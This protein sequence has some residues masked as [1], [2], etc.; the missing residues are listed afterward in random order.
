[1]ALS[2][3]ASGAPANDSQ[4]VE[5]G[6]ITL[7]TQAEASKDHRATKIA[8][9]HDTLLRE[10]FVRERNVA[11]SE[12]FLSEA[13]D[14]TDEASFGE[15]RAEYRQS[16]EQICD[17]LWARD[18]ALGSHE[19][20]EGGDGGDEAD[21][22]RPS[23]PNNSAAHPHK[24][25]S[26]PP[27]E[28]MVT[29]GVSAKKLAFSPETPTGPTA[30][31]PDGS[32]SAAAST[33]PGPS[34]APQTRR[35]SSIATRP[36]ATTVVRPPATSGANKVPR[37]KA[38]EPK[39]DVRRRT[40][41]KKPV[42]V[43]PE[44][45]SELGGYRWYE[46]HL[47]VQAN[48]IGAL[49]PSASKTLTTKDWQAARHE[50]QQIALLNRVELLKEKRLWSFRQLKPHEPPRRHKTNWD[51][52]LDEMKWMRIDFR[53]ERR[54]KIAQ[55]YTIAHWV[56]EWHASS[57]KSSLCLKRSHSHMTK[58][59]TS[60]DPQAASED[61][62]AEQ[63]EDLTTPKKELDH[64][65]AEATTKDEAATADGAEKDLPSMFMDVGTSFYIVDDGNPNHIL[66]IPTYQPPWPNEFYLDENQHKRIVPVSH[67]ITERRV[68]EDVPREEDAA[69]EPVTPTVSHNESQITRK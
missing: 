25:R 23:D 65:E 28:R 4:P 66:D 50:A 12:N 34:Q 37:F 24:R 54:W 55:A 22:R 17:A 31:T 5:I 13:E 63:S 44:T 49:L 60:I 67:L 41:P 27:P 57:D 29:R 53:Q 2:D 20:H 51:S 15:F 69:R 40:A 43:L 16:R 62:P 26:L 56:M 42:I 39:P 7:R 3:A 59:P 30:P 14:V 36:L 33:T 35:R 19:G 46:W 32:A 18:H 11:K 58:S 61:H 68:F 64:S 52:L 1:M 45:N 8:G 48:P 6:V 9:R 21:G 10:L 38:R 47:R